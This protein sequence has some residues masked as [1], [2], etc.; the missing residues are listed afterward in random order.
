MAAY[1][2]TYLNE[3][4]ELLI[5]ETVF[6][7]NLIAAKSSATSAAPNMTYTIV[8]SDVAGEPLA[9]KESGKWKNI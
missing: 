5:T 2:I 4:N 7:R 3:G 1:L 6:M 9:T 8:I